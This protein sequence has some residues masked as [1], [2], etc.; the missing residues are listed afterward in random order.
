VD[1]PLTYRLDADDRI[2]DIRGPW[3]EFARANGA[4]ELT[5]DKVL[6]HLM[7]RGQKVAGGD[8]LANCGDGVVRQGL[9]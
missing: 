6:E 8:R 5:R 4:P 9:A 7:T 3:D 2:V 1:A